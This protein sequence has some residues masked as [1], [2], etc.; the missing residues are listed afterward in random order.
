MNIFKGIL[1]NNFF[2]KLISLILAIL[3]WSY[4]T[5]QVYKET[6]KS[7]KEASSIIKVS[8][9][10]IV[11]KTL[12]IY[13]NIEGTPGTGYR[14][15]LDQIE[16]SPSSSVVAGAPEV[17][18]DLTYISTKPIDVGKRTSSVRDRVELSPIPGCRIGYEGLVRVKIPIARQR[19]R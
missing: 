7:D 6:V 4:I 13:V 17:I 14:V 5:S 16:I 12:P 2:I 11:V 8:G 3:T 15:A 1:F 9:E 19:R 10:K 18:K